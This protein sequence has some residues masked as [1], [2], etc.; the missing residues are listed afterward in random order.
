MTGRFALK[1]ETKAELRLPGVTETALHGAV[2]VEEQACGL[3]MFRVLAVG[4]VEY[5]E[6]EP[7]SLLQG[8]PKTGSFRSTK[9]AL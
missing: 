8:E 7:S 1:H 2:E 5:V 4:E 6:S 9:R 3:T